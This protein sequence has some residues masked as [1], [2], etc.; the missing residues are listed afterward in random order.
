MFLL[1]SGLILGACAS[2][3]KKEESIAPILGPSHYAQQSFNEDF[4]LTWNTQ[5]TH[6]LIAKSIEINKGFPYKT[7]YFEIYDMNT[8]TIVYKDK[9]VQAQLSWLSD[10]EIKISQLPGRPKDGRSKI[11][12]Y[13]LNIPNF[14]K[15]YLK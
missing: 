13:I 4:E 12:T 7:I 5:K 15:S 10:S 11:K 6:C 3:N 1:I 14:D 9:L 2:A 8:D